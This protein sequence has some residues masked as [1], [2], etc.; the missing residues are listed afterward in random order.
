MLAWVGPLGV[1][2]GVMALMVRGLALEFASL[3]VVGAVLIAF[4]ALTG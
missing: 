2:L 1:A 4:A 3:T